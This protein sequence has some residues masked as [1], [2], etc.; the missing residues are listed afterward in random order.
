MRRFLLALALVAMVTTA[1]NAATYVWWEWDGTVPQGYTVTQHGQGLALMIE[2]PLNGPYDIP[3][4]MKM[5]NTYVGATTQGM[6][7]YRT[8]L[9]R[10]GDTTMTWGFPPG[11]NGWGDQVT[12]GMLNPL[13]WT[14]GTQSGT[15][16][17]T[18]YPDRLA[19]NYGRNRGSNQAGLNS[20]NS[21]QDWIKFTLHIDGNEP[22]CEYHYIYQTVGL[23][24]YASGP[25]TE[26]WVYFG[27]NPVV[28][29]AT[30]VT[31]W[32]AASQTLP[33]I[34]I[35]ASP[36]PATIALLGLGLLGLIRRR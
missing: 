7:G 6:T 30:G 15:V 13:N 4:V 31:A 11:P 3:L 1:A 34:I 18:L 16:N 29:G 10:G 9:W 22:F 26:N 2:K 19:N 36:E 25:P 21:P 24:Q 28:T 20:A 8:N 14:S 35:H 33:V 17:D 27:P 23:N 32:T 5:S 12:N